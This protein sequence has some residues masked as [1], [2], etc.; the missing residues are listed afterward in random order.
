MFGKFKEKLK[1]WFKDSSEKIEEDAE[2][3]ETEVEASEDI[4]SPNE[5]ILD[6]S[7]GSEGGK[8][9]KDGE[10]TADNRESKEEVSEKD[11]EKVEKLIEKAKDEKGQN[12]PS[13]FD[14]YNRKTIPD[15]EKIEEEAETIKRDVEEGEKKKKEEKKAKKEVEKFEKELEKADK[16]IEEAK[17]EDLPEVPG[18]FNAGT[19]K[20]EPD[21]ENLGK[22]EVNTENLS[23][24]LADKLA[25][26]NPG[27]KS[28]FGRMKSSFSYKI[29]EEEFDSI[30][31]DLELLLLDNNVALEAV[32]DI[33]DS[34]KEKLVGREI[35]KDQL[36]EEIR[37][38]LKKAIEE[39]LVEPDNPLEFI[40]IAEKPF[41]ILFF[42]INGTGK[43]TSIAKVTSFLKAAGFS[44]VLA[45]GDTFR[46]ASIEQI[47]EHASKL[48]VPVIKQDYGADPA[49]VGF[50]A[51]Q[52]ATKNKIDVVLIDTAG[53]MHTKSNLLAEME[54]IVRVTD[55]DLKLFVAE[56]VAGNDAV[57]QAKAF[58]ETVDIDG[59]ILSKAD[60]DEKGGTVIS[61]SH[62]TGKPI[63]YLGTG[64]NYEDLELFNKQKFVESLGL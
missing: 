2:K 7:S 8:D 43:T 3:I 46:A 36:E 39:I 1:G 34:L 5:D 11:I 45:A 12:V 63:F 61:V 21:L 53:R 58:H 18:K 15:L 51:I 59:S 33:R 52:Y 29:T 57:D 31:D 4:G 17:K 55:P 42:G 9:E 41:K 6:K 64:Q 25:E 27:H 22:G 49:A 20:Y 13:K 32:D 14:A 24:E 44:V 56:S 38:E 48:D 26:A 62:A 60:I 40:K 50:D 37:G 35:K 16:I 10:S 28:F 47:E 54:K 30:F 23:E 19:Q